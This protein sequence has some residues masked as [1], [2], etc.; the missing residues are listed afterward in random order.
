MTTPPPPAPHADP[1]HPPA[2]APGTASLRGLAVLVA[3]VLALGAVLGVVWSRLAPGQR[4]VVIDARTLATLPTESEHVFVDAALF[5]LLGIVGGVLSA[6]VAWRWRRARGPVVLLVLVVASVLGAL[7][8]HVV[9]L[10]LLAQPDASGSPQGT[11]LTAAPQ[12][13]T[14]LVLVGQPLGAALGYVGAASLTSDELDPGGAGVVSSAS[15]ERPADPAEPGPPA[16][17]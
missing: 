3:A 6:V 13:R 2:S 17:R 9:G 7:L 14:W 5:V 4:F 16:A 15:P 12:L 10:A 11:V 8:A 1:W